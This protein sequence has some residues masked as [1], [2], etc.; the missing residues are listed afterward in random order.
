MV[1]ITIIDLAFVL[2]PSEVKQ[3]VIVLSSSE[4][5]SKAA[6]AKMTRSTAFQT[7][8]CSAAQQLQP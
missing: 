8:A 4:A 3:E 5:K 6:G 2:W 7:R 1:V